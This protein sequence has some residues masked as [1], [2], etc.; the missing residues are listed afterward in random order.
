L[1]ITCLQGR[2]I[3]VLANKRRLR[4]DKL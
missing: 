2:N 1:I 4:C 3:F